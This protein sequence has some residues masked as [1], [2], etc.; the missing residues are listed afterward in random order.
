M[1]AYARKVLRL[2]GEIADDVLALI[3]RLTAAVSGMLILFW[4]WVSLPVAFRAEVP[5]SPAAAAIALG[6]TGPL[7]PQGLGPQAL[8]M[9]AGGALLLVVAAGFTAAFAYSAFRCFRM[10]VVRS[11]VGE[12]AMYLIARS[13]GSEALME[14]PL[15]SD[16]SHK[17]SLL[18]RSHTEVAI[19]WSRELDRLDLAY[20]LHRYERLIKR[21][22][23]A[24]PERRKR[25]RRRLIAMHEN[26]ERS[27]EIID[28]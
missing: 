17:L 12:D 27:Y 20:V 19:L 10:G 8:L 3:C 15:I 21:F 2:A 7:R 4:L 16:L 9:L 28:E 26:S 6:P 23:K 24:G 11:R 22:V 14:D 5:E 18:C 1:L 13:R 25:Y